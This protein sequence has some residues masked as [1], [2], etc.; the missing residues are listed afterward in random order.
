[1][2]IDVDAGSSGAFDLLQEFRDADCHD[3]LG[4]S[5][6]RSVG[7]RRPTRYPLRNQAMVLLSFKTGLR[8]A[9]IANLTRLDL[10]DGP[11]PWR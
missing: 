11:W 6:R 5:C 3:S 1:M 2:M 7:L 9:E 8:A 4:R 10:A